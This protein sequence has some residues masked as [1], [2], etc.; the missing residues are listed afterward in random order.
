M[1]WSDR[2]ALS[3]R[4]VLRFLVL[5]PREAFQLERWAQLL[6]H[7]SRVADRHYHGA[8][9]AVLV[10]FLA[11]CGFQPLYAEHEVAVNQDNLAAIKVAPIKDRVGQILEWSLRDSL[12]P[13]DASVETRYTLRVTL[14]I[15]YVELGIQRDATSTRARVDVVANFQM[16]D[17][18]GKPVYTGRSQSSGYYNE[19]NDAYNN[20]I[21]SEGAIE[22]ALRQV[23]DDILARLA[24][25]LSRPQ[26]A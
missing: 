5:A 6:H 11:A 22:R 15:G 13:T 25:F 2:I 10:L 8:C 17:A 20:E 24:L 1:S 23:S 14:T 9:L 18:N 19:L 26:A 7:K 21:A 12:N 3:A 4:C 16:V